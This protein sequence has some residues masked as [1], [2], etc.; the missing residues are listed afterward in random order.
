MSKEAS[1]V[2]GISHWCHCVP[3]DKD[4]ADKALSNNWQNNIFK[5]HKKIHL[6]R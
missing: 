3:V 1:Q 2:M 5:K 6:L 4:A